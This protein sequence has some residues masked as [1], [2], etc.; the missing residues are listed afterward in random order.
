MKISVTHKS[1][2]ETKKYPYIGINPEKDL[3]VLFSS[4]GTGA[5]I[6]ST[7]ENLIGV[8]YDTFNENDYKLFQGEVILKNG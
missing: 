5:I 4:T 6:Y 3:I 2:E 8:S 1:E 7:N